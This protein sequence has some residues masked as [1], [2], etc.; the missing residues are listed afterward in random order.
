MERI[1]DQTFITCLR[2][3]VCLLCYCQILPTNVFRWCRWIVYYGLCQIKI[4]RKWVVGSSP[5]LFFGGGFCVFYVKLD[6]GVGG[7]V[8]SGQSWYLSRIFWGHGI[9]LIALNWRIFKIQLIKY[10]TLLFTRGLRENA[11][12]H[13]KIENALIKTR[14]RL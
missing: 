7:W 2:G 8:V 11:I 9:Y 10:T 4:T 12:Q 1:C 5:N 3:E 6:M 13:L 14:R